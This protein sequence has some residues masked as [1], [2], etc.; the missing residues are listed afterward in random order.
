MDGNMKDAAQRAVYALK[1]AS[2]CFMLLQSETD[3]LAQVMSE[4]LA[5]EA[6]ELDEVISSAMR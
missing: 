6:R 1:A 2:E 4:W 5:R 3:D